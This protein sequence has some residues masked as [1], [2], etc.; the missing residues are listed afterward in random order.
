MAGLPWARLDTN[1]PTHDK[2]L[3][4]LGNG[5]RGKAAAFVYVCGL[6]YSVGQGSDGIIKRAALPFIHGTAGDARLLVDARLWIPVEGGW[7]IVN[8]G[9][10]QAAGM[11]SQ[12]EQDKRSE[13]ARRSANAR[14]HGAES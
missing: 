4:L 2:I 11:S 14:W 3:E 12:V 5:A 8:Y 9:T 13:A 6:A 1:L 7:Q 10:R